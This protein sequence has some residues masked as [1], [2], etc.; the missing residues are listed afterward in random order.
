MAEEETEEEARWERRLTD[1][2]IIAPGEGGN[3]VASLFFSTRNNEA[4]EKRI[5]LINTAHSDLLKAIKAV[6]ERV[7]SEKAKVLLTDIM[8]NNSE[9]FGKGRG[10]GNFWPEGENSIKE[11]FDGDELVRRKIDMVRLGACD[12]VCDIFTLGGGTGCGSGPYIIYRAKKDEITRGRHFAIAIWPEIRDGGQRHF[13]AIGGL[14]RLLK[15]EDEQNADLVIL[16]SNEYLAKS[17][18]EDK[19]KGKEDR[20]F[21]MN[22][23]IADLIE[24][25]IAPGRSES[26]V[27]IEIS[28]Y[29]T[30]PAALGVYHAVPC[31]SMGNDIELIGL[32]A[33]LDDAV[34]KALFPMDAK[35]A[36]MVWAIFRVPQDYYGVDEFEPERMNEIFDNWAEQNIIGE[37]KYVAVTY[38]RDLKETFDVLLLLGGPS[39]DIS[40]SYQMYE[41]FKKTLS[42]G[43]GNIILPGR[44]GKIILPVKT[45][46]T[47]EKNLNDY[48]HHT[49]EVQEALGEGEL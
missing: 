11:D 3:K 17:I 35:S 10:A 6:S 27:T 49:E 47:L 22:N 42:R 12:A 13:N 41:R 38:D 34:S 16:I 25:M 36:T 46:D 23:V 43:S 14:S 26:D 30:W 20:Y 32:E 37:V 40:K 8:N 9:R 29:T 1:W 39:I 45:L 18:S 2:G 7:E 48:L 33:A 28:D 4:I 44:G 19:V 15:Y 31:L 5:L 21:Q 24:L